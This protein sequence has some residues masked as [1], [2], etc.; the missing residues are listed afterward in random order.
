MKKFV[1]NVQ[2]GQAYPDA[3]VEDDQAHG[4]VKVPLLVARF[5]GQPQLDRHVR[6][7]VA[8]HQHSDLVANLTVAAAR[9]LEFVVLGN[10]GIRD[11]L[12]WGL[13]GTTLDPASTALLQ[14]VVDA[15]DVPCTDAVAKFGRN[16][17]LPGNWQA[18]MHILATAS[19]YSNAVDTNIL[20]GVGRLLTDCVGVVLHTW[21]H[22]R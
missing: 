3:A 16:C 10:S 8:T 20:A 17:H 14:D 22:R 6:A 11:A 13:R 15:Q 19:G 4:L 1:A 12:R 9:M 5:A 21:L 7:A 2:A 18:V